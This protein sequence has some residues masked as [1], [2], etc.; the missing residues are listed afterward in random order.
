MTEQELEDLAIVEALEDLFARERRGLLEG[1]LEA[2]VR[3]ADRRE[4]LLARVPSLR[5]G[6]PVLERLR[7]S[8]ARNAGLL[9]AAA[10][11]VRSASARV[12]SLIEGP[13]PLNTYDMN[14][15]RHQLGGKGSA[16]IRRL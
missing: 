15:Q 13:P 11:G 5:I 14:G 12:R 8:A 3:L 7:S 4:S 10:Q 9:A 1:D 2:V 6:R 16:T